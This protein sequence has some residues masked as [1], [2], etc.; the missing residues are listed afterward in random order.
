ME[1]TLTDAATAKQ[2]LSW[3]LAGKPV[4]TDEQIDELVADARSTVDGVDVWTGSALNES[5]A[6]GWAW[7]SALTADQYDLAGGSGKSLTRSQWHAHCRRMTAAF[8]SGSLSVIAGNRQQGGLESIGLTT[9]TATVYPPA[10][11]T[12]STLPPELRGVTING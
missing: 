1:R 4:L 10:E 5:A 2:R 12:T 6:L 11:T 9:E 8:T 3:S 7:K